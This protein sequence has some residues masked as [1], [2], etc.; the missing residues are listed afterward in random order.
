MLYVQ[1]IFKLT[2]WRRSADFFI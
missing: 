1:K 2:L